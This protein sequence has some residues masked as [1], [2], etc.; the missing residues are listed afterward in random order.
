MSYSITH[1]YKYIIK[2]NNISALVTGDKKTNKLTLNEH[3]LVTNFS[4]I[5][6]VAGLQSH[7]YMS[8]NAVNFKQN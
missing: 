8:I 1:K 4:S 7:S 6:S 5:V 2:L 3:Y